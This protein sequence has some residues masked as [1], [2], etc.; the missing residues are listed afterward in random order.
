M[1]SK[2]AQIS[3]EMKISSSLQQ[4]SSDLENVAWLTRDALWDVQNAS[5]YPK[6]MNGFFRVELC[7]EKNQTRK[8]SNSEFSLPVPRA[9]IMWKNS[10]FWK[11]IDGFSTQENF[12]LRCTLRREVD[13]VTICSF[14]FFRTRDGL[15]E[16]ILRDIYVIL[17]DTASFSSSPRSPSFATLSAD[18]TSISHSPVS[19]TSSNGDQ[20]VH[21][22][23]CIVQREASKQ[24]RKEPATA[25]AGGR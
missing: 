19:S 9:R 13:A 17:P 10:S 8:Q 12:S 5:P 2:M 20:V 1:Q 21:V 16:R 7:M 3:D 11:S 22:V 15:S 25:Q 24:R 4:M 18:P 14:R 6:I 23:V